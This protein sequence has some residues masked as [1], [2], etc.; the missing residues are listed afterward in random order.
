MLPLA[1]TD[2]G[3]A[4]AEAPLTYEVLADLAGVISAVQSA[5][6]AV[7]SLTC[8][9]RALSSSCV[10]NTHKNLD[11]A[12]L[13]TAELRSRRAELVA[14]L[15]QADVLLAGA[16]VEQRRNC[17]KEGC[18]CT[19][20]EPHGPYAYLQV[21]GRM[22]Y[23]PAVLA[24]AVRAR[25]EV[26]RRLREPAGGDL[27]DQPGAAVP[28]GAGL[29]DARCLRAGAV[30][31]AAERRRGRRWSR[32]WPTWPSPRWPGA[33]CRGEPRPPGGERR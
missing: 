21:A 24:E 31:A 15:P 5:T 17:G 13:S 10:M 3:P 33:G 2:R 20:G 9:V 12:R 1:W 16:L 26:S 27:G 22:M 19:R 32:R 28:A 23:V 4:A 7:M 8:H 14:G 30:P 25:L 6:R 11:L 18:R 29:A